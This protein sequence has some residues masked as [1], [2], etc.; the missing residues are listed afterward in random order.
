MGPFNER[1][2]RV[3]RP[4]GVA[5][6]GSSQMLNEAYYQEIDTGSGTL[7]SISEI[8]A[9]SGNQSTIRVPAG[10]RH[11]GWVFSALNS[12]GTAVLNGVVTTD[13][14]SY[15]VKSS[16]FADGYV[17]ISVYPLFGRDVRWS[18]LGR[19]RWP[20]GRHGRGRSFIV[21]A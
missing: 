1:Q 7:L 14:T 18:R 9:I 19:G 21:S 4:P 13:G 16:Y 2:M 12:M 3:G 5:Y 11:I 10:R 17:N 15:P 6:Y 20:P 8:N